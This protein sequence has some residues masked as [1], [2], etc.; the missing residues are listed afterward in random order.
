MS[1]RI[2]NKS[3]AAQ[4]D[5]LFG[6]LQVEQ[7]RANGVYTVDG[8]RL[9]YPV[10][11]LAELQELDPVQFPKARLY[12]GDS[13][14]DYVWSGSAYVEVPSSDSKAN[15]DSIENLTAYVNSL[16]ATKSIAFIFDDGYE[17]AATVVKPLFDSYG[18]EFGLAIPYASLANPSRLGLQGVKDLHYKGVEILNHASSGDVMNSTAKGYGAVRGELATCWSGLAA[19][20]VNTTGF[21]TPS[22]ILNASFLPIVKGFSSYAFTTATSTDVIR[23]GTD[24]HKMHRFSIEAA[25]TQQ[26]I[27]SLD[28]L[29]AAEDGAIVYY[30]HSIVANDENYLKLVATIEYAKANNIPILAPSQCIS[31]SV[32]PITSVDRVFYEGE[33]LFNNPSLLTVS[34]GGTI[35]VNSTSKDTTVTLPNAGDYLVQDTYNF[36]S[37]YNNI[38][39][40]TTFSLLVRDLA[41]TVTN[42]KVGMRMYSEENATGTLLLQAE[43]DDISLNNTY[44]RYYQELIKG[45]A[46]SVLFYIRLSTNSA[47]SVLLREPTL[48]FGSSIQGVRYFEEEEQGGGSGF[49]LEAFNI[50]A[51]TITAGSGY[52]L[53]VLPAEDNDLFAT[54]STSVVFKRSAVVEVTFSIIAS[55]TNVGANWEGGAIILTDGVKNF[56]SAPIAGGS[57]YLS[58]ATSAT[59]RVSSGDI[60]RASAIAYGKDLAIGTSSRLT[61][62]EL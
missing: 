28:D 8:V 57:S 1:N 24:V 59:L 11:S 18:I 4:Q 43:E 31:K 36:D 32:N 54:S 6:E 13:Y 50:S 42:C 56:N 22:S 33:L 62:S 20:G 55:G 17:T 2:V 34:G 26:C 21:Q 23:A 12:E 47:G 27:D 45:T 44:V 29:I 9:I 51:Q 37:L 25:T 48:R 53:I 35:A 38:E 14:T 15:A 19:I 3:L 41:G 10:N 58:G 16:S 7:K 40:L 46:K 52:S 49:G 39:A 60:L 5:L 30:A 61:V